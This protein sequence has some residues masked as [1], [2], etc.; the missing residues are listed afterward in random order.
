MEKATRAFKKA[1]TPNSMEF[2]TTAGSTD[3]VL[4]NAERKTKKWPKREKAEKQVAAMAAMVDLKVSEKRTLEKKE[5]GK[6]GVMVAIGEE[7]EETKDNG[8]KRNLWI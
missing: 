1:R 4:A 2:V 3:T 6:A 7:K 5:K 8:G